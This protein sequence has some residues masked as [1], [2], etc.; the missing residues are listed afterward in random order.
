MI[1]FSYGIDDTV[2][3]KLFTVCLVEEFKKVDWNNIGVKI[4]GEYFNNFRFT[5]NVVFFSARGGPTKNDI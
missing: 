1:D 3:P 2:T 5:D 4:D